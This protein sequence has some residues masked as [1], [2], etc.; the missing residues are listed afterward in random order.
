MDTLD[1]TFT[2]GRIQK[3]SFNYVNS[4][5]IRR[6]PPAIPHIEP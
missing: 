5:Q 2:D 6:T 4:L 3:I 1:C